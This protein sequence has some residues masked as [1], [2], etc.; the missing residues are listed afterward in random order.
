M[1]VVVC[2]IEVYVVVSVVCSVDGHSS[3]FTDR[4]V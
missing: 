3:L 4:D 2:I 1:L